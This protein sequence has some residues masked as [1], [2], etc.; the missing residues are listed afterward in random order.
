MN[1]NIRQFGFVILLFS[2][3]TIFAQNEAMEDIDNKTGKEE[4]P[5]RYG[6]MTDT[7]D[8]KNY[9]T[10]AI[11]NQIWMAENMSY[12]PSVN[13]I[14]TA[15]F[16]WPVYY[17]FGHNNTDISAARLTDNYKN[18]GVLY[19]WP[20]AQKACPQGWRLPTGKD[21]EILIKYMGHHSI[22][23]NKMKE[24]G[25]AHWKESKEIVTNSSGFSALPG[26]AV[27]QNKSW[28]DIGTKANFWGTEFR[29][30]NNIS[31]KSFSTYSSWA[32]G[33]YFQKDSGLSV[34]C[35]KN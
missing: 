5:D 2:A 4:N 24:T 27:T 26:G 16:K 15:S 28:N 17:V 32:E 18:Y 21:W 11:G 22:A 3:L 33:T 25:T 1:N 7:R 8:N 6:S 19:N 9:K 30:S 14:T 10:V 35:L 12:L 23:G 13:P 31:T 29:D 34:R 20:A